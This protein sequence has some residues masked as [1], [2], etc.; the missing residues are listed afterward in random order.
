MKV[1]ETQYVVRDKTRRGWGVI[2]SPAVDEGYDGRLGLGAEAEQ[3]GEAIG[4]P[5][6]TTERGKRKLKNPWRNPPEF[7]PQTAQVT[8]FLQKLLSRGGQ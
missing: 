7:L 8:S 2:L 6:K 3:C 4:M 5:A 1:P